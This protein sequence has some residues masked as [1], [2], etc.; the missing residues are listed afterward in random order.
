VVSTRIKARPAP[1]EKQLTLCFEPGL[2]ER[3]ASLRECIATG[4]YQRGL[5]NVA[6]TLEKA[7]GNL[8]VELSEDPTRKFGVDSLER[9]I[10]KFD[11]LT[12]IYYLVEKFL[13]KHEAEHDAAL[14]QIQPL[15]EQLGPL[16]KRAGLA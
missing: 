7:P 13:H 12:P 4:I 9:Y 15:L 14:A 3:Y 8:S 5:T 16:L 6:P 1:T 11:D 2:V 10:E